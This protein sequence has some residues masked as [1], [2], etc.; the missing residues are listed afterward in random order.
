MNPK[1]LEHF[2]RI[3]QAG[4]LSRAAERLETSQSVLSRDLRELEEEMG[5]SLFTRHPRGVELTSAGMALKGQAQ[6]ILGLLGNLRDEVNSA[7]EQ[8]SG[9]VAFGMPAS[10]TAIL[11]G[12]LVHSFHQRYPGVKLQIR[13]GLSTNLR[14]ALLARELDFAMLVAPVAEPQLV[15]RPLL[16]E[17]FVMIGPAGS[18]LDGRRSISVDEVASYPLILP[19]MPNSTRML[20]EMAFE[21]A[22]RTPQVMLETDDAALLTQFV[23]SGLGYAVLP[24]SAVAMKSHLSASLVQVP[25]K[26]LGVTRILAMPAGVAMS[27]ATH[28]LSQM[29]CERLKD[30]IARKQLKGQYVGP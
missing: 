29:L 25:V 23:M 10:M 5:V 27:I 19:M 11:T 21:R 2:L 8:P 4:S 26:G 12:S 3:A 24:Q 9:R 30:L 6:V 20:I 7:A 13:E 28:R 14:A 22:G 15:V 18:S 16:I 17:P 1:K